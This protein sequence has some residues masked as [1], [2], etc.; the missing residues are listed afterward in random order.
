[1]RDDAVL[2]RALPLDRGLGPQIWRNHKVEMPWPEL[3]NYWSET[4][5]FRVTCSSTETSA[6]QLTLALILGPLLSLVFLMFKQLKSKLNSSSQGALVT[7]AIVCIFNHKPDECSKV[8]FT[9]S[10]LYCVN[11]LKLQRMVIIFV[12][13]GGLDNL[14]SAMLDWI[15][16]CLLPYVCCCFRRVQST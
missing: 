15:N 14:V 6:L 4:V 16:C 2:G 8:S 1:M 11:G 7:C 3:I 13:H 10:K 5:W 9:Y 12:A